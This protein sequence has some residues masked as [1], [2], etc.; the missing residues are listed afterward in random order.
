MK[1]YSVELLIARRA[2]FLMARP[3]R[4]P[5]MALWASESFWFRQKYSFFLILLRYIRL[6]VSFRI[7]AIFTCND[8]EIR[9]PPFLGE[10]AKKKFLD[11]FKWAEGVGG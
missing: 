1:A 5:C 6:K 8:D 3:L 10:A 9:D 11:A 4:P 2:I 7:K